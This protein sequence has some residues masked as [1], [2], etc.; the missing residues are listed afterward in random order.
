MN[1]QQ[2]LAAL[3]EYHTAED[4]VHPTCIPRVSLIRASQ[5]TVPLHILHEPAL[6]IVAQGK[7]Q[8]FLGEQIFHYDAQ[9]YLIVSVDLPIGG[10]VIEAEPAEPYL[11]FKLSFDVARLSELVVEM[12]LSSE[13]GQHPSPGLALS[14]ADPA[15]LD[16]TLRLLRLLSTPQDAPILAP[17]AEREL[18]YRLLTGAQAH[19]LRQIALAEGKLQGV[20]RAIGWLKAHYRRP[21]HMGNLTTEA[22]MSASALHHHFKT[23][24]TMS[25]LQYQKQLR[26]Q[27]ARRLMLSASHD[28]ATV[29]FSVGYESPSQFSREYRRHFGAPPLRDAARLKRPLHPD[30]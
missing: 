9:H 25:P 29:G 27:E 11:C 2:A 15:L 21:F 26:L 10:Q 3:I 13:S 30:V 1:Q 14:P 20:N 24:T 18:L 7:K 12:G 6:C 16:A 22:R 23:V 19:K 5:P 4:G 28:A 8:V 17:L